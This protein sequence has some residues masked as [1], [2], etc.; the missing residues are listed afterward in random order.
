MIHTY[1]FHQFCSFREPRLI[2]P[3]RNIK[4]K[5][6]NSKTDKQPQNNLPVLFSGQLSFSM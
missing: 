1:Y 2:H 5:T 6:S 4:T 3:D